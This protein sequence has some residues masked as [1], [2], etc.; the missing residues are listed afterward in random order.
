MACFFLWQ[1]DR[2][3]RSKLKMRLNGSLTVV[4]G[5]V[6]VI[7]H[8]GPSLSLSLFLSLFLSQAGTI[9]NLNPKP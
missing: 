6:L 4:F 3:G 8:S 9:T 2:H 7:S 5:M 1:F